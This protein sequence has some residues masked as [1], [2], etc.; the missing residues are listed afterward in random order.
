MTGPE[1]RALMEAMLPADVLAGVAAGAGLQRRDRK[2]DAVRLL[3]TILIAAASPAGGRQADMHR[4]YIEAAGAPVTRGSF[5]DWFG[6]PLEATLTE[7]SARARARVQA[8]PADLPAPMADVHDW[9]IVDSTL[10]ML[11]RPLR[12][13]FP[14]AGA[15]AAVKVHKTLSVG[16]GAVVDYHFSP[17]RDHDSPHLAL[18]ETWRGAGLL[19]D[20]GYASVARLAACRD[21]DIAV[22]IRLKDSWRPVVE[23][24]ARADLKQTFVPGTDLDLF[25]DGVDLGLRNVIDVDAEVGAGVAMRLVGVAV[26]RKGYRFYLTNVGRRL[27][28][29]Q[30]ADIYR[31]R[32][33]IETNNKLDKS[34]HRLHQIDARRP[35]AV[36]ALL[37]ASMIASILVGSIVHAHNRATRPAAGPRQRP[38][39]HHGLVARM[40]AL[41]GPRVADAFER[42]GADADRAWAHIAAALVHA[43]QDPNWRSKPSILDQLRGWPAKPGTKPRLS[44][45]APVL[46]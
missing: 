43:G 44:S 41:A 33:E 35:A 23:R 3:R 15:Y 19:I 29:H 32:W 39:L 13:E 34:G 20:L 26:P 28:P 6:G 7:L 12:R 8:A 24:V 31:V 36:R 27:G 11:P 22:I 45:R 5:Y 18:D 14:G 30:I 21:L 16:R 37:H 40:L 42:T 2:R 1:L 25:L 10:V 17:A 4:Q 46:R 9:W 38:P